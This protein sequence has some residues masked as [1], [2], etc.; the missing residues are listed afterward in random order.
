M[1]LPSPRTHPTQAP[2]PTLQILVVEMT[3]LT[4]VCLPMCV[5]VSGVTAI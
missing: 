4:R 3:T 1:G 2:P 5:C